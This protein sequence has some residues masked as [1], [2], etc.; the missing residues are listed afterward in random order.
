MRGNGRFS[1]METKELMAQ[2]VQDPAQAGEVLLQPPKRPKKKRSIK[3]IVLLSLAGIA[4]LALAGNAVLS[5]LRGPLPTYVQTQT[6]AAGDISQSLSTTGTLTSGQTVVV[7]SPVTAPLAEVKVEAGQIVN[8]G[9]LLATFD[10][11]P[12]E[13]AYR[14][15]SA[16]YESGQLQKSDALT[17]SDSAQARFN[18][19]AANLNNLAVQKDKA[20]A[21][22]NSLTA[23]YEA[24]ADKQSEEA[25]SVKAALD[26]AAADLANQQ[27]ALSAA[28]ATYDAEKQAVLSDSAKRQL[29]LA[30]VPSSLSVQSAKEDLARGRDGVTAPISG[31][32]TSL[33]AVPGSSAAAYGPLC[34]IQSLS[35]VYVDVALSRY[36]LEKVK[37][38]QSA[39]VTTLGRTYTGT[40]ASIDAMATAGA[41]AT[42]TATAYVHAKVQ[43]DAPDGDIKLGL[44]ANVVIA[45]GEAKGVLSLPISAVNTD[46]SGQFC[47]V[48]ENGAA[49]RRDVKTGLSSDTQVEIASGISAGDEVILNPQD[50]T[51]GI[52]VQSAKEDLARG[53]DGVTAPISG[54]VTSLS[55][56]PGSS[57]AAYGPLCTIQS[58]SDVY[59]DVALS[60]YD[61]EKVKP[62]QSAVVTTLGRT[63]TGTVASIDAMATAGASATGTATAYVHAKVQ[64]DAPDGDIKL[65]LE[66]NVVIATGEA[67]GVLSLPI[68][69]VNTDVSGQFCYVVENGAAVRRDVKTGLSSDTQVEIASGISAGDEVILNPQ[70]VTEGMAVSSDPAAAA[71]MPADAGMGAVMMG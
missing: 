20:S 29:E 51:E 31:V 56:V 50:V 41:S 14:Q 2:N 32:V 63:Y 60:R 42:G 16:A 52:S 64:L 22:V 5:A 18:D 55:A 26:A 47:Y 34:T 62:G 39:V 49:V 15:A 45:T 24:L 59:V 71:Q 7:P 23:Q 27:Q 28:K 33:S 25:L 66:A 10:T 35:D 65:G 46:V 61:L 54:V 53:R 4:V 17:A 44:E 67:K 11:E 6:A 70:D 38:G 57:A 21:A 19:A 30:Q 58:L 48:V 3:K 40:V 43:L 13:R 37:P 8:A 1:K 9:D 68:S 12:L 36:D 69:A